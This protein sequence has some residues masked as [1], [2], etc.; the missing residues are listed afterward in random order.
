MS[1]SLSVHIVFYVLAVIS[2]PHT[3]AA[4][5]LLAAVPLLALP[6]SLIIDTHNGLCTAMLHK[7]ASRLQHVLFLLNC[8]NTRRA[9]A[10]PSRAEL[11]RAGPYRAEPS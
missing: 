3:A 1:V 7:L 5:P 4:D 6:A 10:G 2:T 11:S 9:L 8:S